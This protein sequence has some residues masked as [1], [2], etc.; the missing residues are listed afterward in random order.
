MSHNNKAKIQADCFFLWH[1][2]KMKTGRRGKVLSIVLRFLRFYLYVQYYFKKLGVWFESWG[3]FFPFRWLNEGKEWAWAVVFT[4]CLIHEG[5]P[6]WSILL[7]LMTTPQVKL[8]LTHFMDEGRAC[9]S[10][11]AGLKFEFQVLLSPRAVTFA[12]FQ[13]YRWKTGKGAFVA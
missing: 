7:I 4:E 13:F 11:V 10:Y 6:T 5:H 12:L 2:L 9:T 8:Y 1:V 3:R